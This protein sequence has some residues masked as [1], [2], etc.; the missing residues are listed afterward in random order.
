M[1]K[2]LINP[3]FIQLIETLKEKQYLKSAEVE[4]VFKSIDRRDFIA[5]LFAYVDTA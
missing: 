1:F 4:A 3:H 5:E 2:E